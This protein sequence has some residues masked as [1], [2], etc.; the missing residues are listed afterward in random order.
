MATLLSDRARPRLPILSLLFVALV[1]VPTLVDGVGRGEPRPPARTY[2]GRAASTTRSARTSGYALAKNYGELP[3]RFEPN[4]GQAGEPVKFLAR[5]DHFAL[6]LTPTEAVFSFDVPG[7]AELQPRRVEQRPE[8]FPL[9][10]GSP[11]KSAILR[12]ALLN[13]N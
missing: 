12:L 8:S 9:H 7:A 1:I 4:L 11:H 3:L 10:R 6:F 2:N 13:G 5:G